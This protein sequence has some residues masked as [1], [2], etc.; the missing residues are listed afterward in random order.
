MSLR[1]KAPFFYTRIQ[2]HPWDNVKEYPDDFEISV[3]YD[4]FAF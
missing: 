1:F 2:S 3:Y 4:V